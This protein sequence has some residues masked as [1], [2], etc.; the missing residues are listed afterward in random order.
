[1]ALW[2]DGIFPAAF[3]DISTVLLLLLGYACLAGLGFFVGAMPFFWLVA[4][5]CRRV[6]GGPYIV[7]DHVTILTGPNAGTTTKVYELT[8]G[9]AGDLLPKVELGA[10]AREKHLDIYDDFTLLR[11][12]SSNTAFHDAPSE[13][14]V[15]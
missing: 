1:M 10:E 4:R 7:G 6:N 3:F 13:S 9:Q 12:S 15:A 2:N 11:A 14:N 8:R 5:V